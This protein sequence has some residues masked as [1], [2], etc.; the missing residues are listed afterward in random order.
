[1]R[2]TIN[3]FITSLTI[4]VFA[5]SC[6]PSQK[7]TIAM[8]SLPTTTQ[9]QTNVP[10]LGQSDA[11]LLNILKTDTN[12]YNQFITQALPKNIQIIYGQ[13]NRGTNNVPKTTT[14]YFNKNNNAYF[15]PAST[16]KFVVAVLALQ[17][18]KAIGNSSI[19]KNTTM[20][21]LSNTPLQTM[22]FN[23]ATTQNGKPTI[24]HY[25]KKILL[26]SDNDAFNRLYEF[27]GQDY[28]NT[29]LQKRGYNAEIVHRLSISLPIAE[30]GKTNPIRFV[31]STGKTL[32]EQGM[33]T[34]KYK[35]LAYTGKR[36]D[37]LG[38]AHYAGG[39]L[40]NQPMDFSFKNRLFLEDLH[41]QIQSITLPETVPVKKRFDITEDD[42]QFLLQYMSQLPNETTYPPY[43]DQPADYW[44]SFCKFLYFGSKP[45][46]LPNNIRMFNKIGKAYGQLVD[47][48]YFVDFDKNIEFYLSAVIYANA[49][50]T[51]NDDNYDFD[52]VGFPFMEQLGKIIYNYEAQRTKTATPNLN[53]FKFSYN[54]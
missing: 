1:M 53:A 29:E 44:P 10:I 16:V 18:L 30:N 46:P 4:L 35:H 17:K 19:N 3:G 25:I 9:P 54:K 22:V 38:K 27:L 2:L 6:K 13:I 39:K 48:T 21:T 8:P 26:V 50:E 28:I 11:Y 51:L 47:A 31:D 24:A 32:L 49:D 14:Y 33:L 42:R 40:I 34:A 20:L 7:N 15:Y 43:A 41:T 12:F 52:T 45:G 5:L 37:S 23:D 36:T